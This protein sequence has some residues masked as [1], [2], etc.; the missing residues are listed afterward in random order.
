MLSLKT[1]KI[2][3]LIFK[4]PEKNCLNGLTVHNDMYVC[5]KANKRSIYLSI[6]QG[7]LGRVGQY[8]TGGTVEF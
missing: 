4:N 7:V 2:K 6:Q 1:W 8:G 3:K 5:L